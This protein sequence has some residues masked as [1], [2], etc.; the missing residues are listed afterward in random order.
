MGTRV[1]FMLGAK[2]GLESIITNAIPEFR[3]WFIKLYEEY[4]SDYDVEVINL[5]D[6]ILSEGDSVFDVESVEC[7]T[8]IDKL[9]DAFVGDYCDH[10]DGTKLLK[11]TLH[12][13]MK[14][15]HYHKVLECFEK[16]S[17]ALSF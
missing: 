12:P 13:V 10:G 6:R 14:I 4:P 1:E 15:H 7:A 3:D 8:E 5:A 17:T 9:V 11:N 2:D 16:G